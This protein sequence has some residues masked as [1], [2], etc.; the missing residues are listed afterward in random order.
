MQQELKMKK[1]LLVVFIV[2]TLF[3]I[4]GCTASQEY[5]DNGLPG[6]IKITVYYDENQNKVMDQGEPGLTDEVSI[7]QDISCLA[8]KEEALT[9]AVTDG[10]G[11]TVFKDLK[12]GRYCVAYMGNKITT[13]RLTVEVSLSSEQVAQVNFELAEKE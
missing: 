8:G 2:C 5:T 12:P 1:S 7:S 9:R 4:A 13:T 10:N 3:I 6:Q 11:S